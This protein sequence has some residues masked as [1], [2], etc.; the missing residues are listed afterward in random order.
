[1]H[2]KVKAFTPEM[3]QKAK[4]LIAQCTTVYLHS[5]KRYFISVEQ[6]PSELESELKA[7][8]CIV[9][10]EERYDMD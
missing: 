2:W 9:Q 5:A 4:E 6:M 7:L 1:M 3:Y 10:P 8:G